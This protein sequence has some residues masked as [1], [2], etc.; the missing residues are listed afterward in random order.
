MH[1]YPVKQPNLTRKFRQT[2]RPVLLVI[3]ADDDPAFPLQ[4][5]RCTR[6]FASGT[7][8]RSESA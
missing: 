5:Q 1:P 7:A 3:G 2:C 6:S 4:A 8:T